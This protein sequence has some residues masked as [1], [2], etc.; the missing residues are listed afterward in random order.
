MFL[1]LRIGEQKNWGQLYENENNQFLYSFLAVTL[2]WKAKEKC[3]FH[4]VIC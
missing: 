1:K 2:D 4:P 3:G